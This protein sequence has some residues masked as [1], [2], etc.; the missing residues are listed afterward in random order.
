MGRRGKSLVGKLLGKRHL[1]HRE[2]GRLTLRW[3]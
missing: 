2:D 1:E 3:S